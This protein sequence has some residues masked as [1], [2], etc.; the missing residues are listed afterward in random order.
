MSIRPKIAE[1]V[2]IVGA[3]VGSPIGGFWSRMIATTPP[4]TPP[5]WTDRRPHHQQPGARGPRASPVVVDD[6]DG[7]TDGDA[8]GD[9]ADPCTR[10]RG[11]DPIR[12]VS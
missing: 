11:A 1:I 7:D 3:A 9:A 12:R 6:A 2:P 4:H 5:V 8:D 10:R